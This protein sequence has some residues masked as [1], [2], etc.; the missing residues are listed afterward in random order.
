MGLE[1]GQ[2]AQLQQSVYESA[3]TD[4]NLGRPLHLV[5]IAFDVHLVASIMMGIDIP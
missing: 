4:I 1:I 3:V 2:G 5:V